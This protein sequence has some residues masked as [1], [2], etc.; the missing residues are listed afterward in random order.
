M[1]LKQESKENRGAG[2]GIAKESSNIAREQQYCGT[3]SASGFL[4]QQHP[5]NKNGC[6]PMLYRT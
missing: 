1:A 3:P 6:S 5:G 4:Q 2:P